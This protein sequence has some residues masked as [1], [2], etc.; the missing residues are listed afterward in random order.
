[1]IIRKLIWDG[2]NIS[3]IA[4]HEVT[5]VEV[6]EV[7]HN[8]PIVEQGKKDRLLIIGFSLNKRMLTIILDPEDQKGAYYPVTARSA[9]RS[10]RKIYENEKGGENKQ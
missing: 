6:E 9:S 4:R 2:W 3:H 7:C 10:E 1:M 5:Q 8:N